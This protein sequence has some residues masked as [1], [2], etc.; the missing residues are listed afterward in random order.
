MGSYGV[1]EER[2]LAVGQE[3][4]DVEREE[5]LFG[6]RPEREETFSGSREKKESFS[7]PKLPD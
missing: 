6:I 1:G 3:V 2:L 5:G 7:R 4:F